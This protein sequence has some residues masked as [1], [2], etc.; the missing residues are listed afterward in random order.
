MENLQ[1]MVV[2]LLPILGEPISTIFEI[3]QNDTLP[4]LRLRL[5]SGATPANLTG[6]TVHLRIAGIGTRTMVM[7]DLAQAIVRYDWLAADTAI[8]G[9]YTAEVKVQYA[10]SARQTIPTIGQIVIRVHRE[11]PA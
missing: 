5:A 3:K 10:G 9:T 8:P 6:A 1:F 4:P 7:E 11:V 2:E